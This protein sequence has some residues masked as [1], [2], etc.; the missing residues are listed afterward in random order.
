MRYADIYP[1]DISNGTG[2]RVSLFVQGCDK[3]C[4]GCF[5]SETWDFNGGKSYHRVDTTWEILNLCKPDYIAGLSILGGEPLNPKNIET[6][7]NLISHFKQTYPN[8]NVWVWTGY[9]IDELNELY[10]KDSILNALLSNIDVLIDGSFIESQ[11]DL[12]LKWRG[13]SN[14]RIWVNKNGILVNETNNT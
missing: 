7:Y 10:S 4:L 14:Q 2:I 13:S 1:F 8:K 12:S 9:T 11:K 6:V 5:N 3:H